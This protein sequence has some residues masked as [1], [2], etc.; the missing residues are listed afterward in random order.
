[1]LEKAVVKVVAP[2]LKVKFSKNLTT[3]YSLIDDVLIIGKDFKSA[4]E[5][6][7]AHIKDAH[8]FEKVHIYSLAMWTLFHEIGHYKTKDVSD[9]EV[10][11]DFFYGMALMNA[12]NPKSYFYLPREW[13][14]SEWAINFFTAHPCVSRLLNK[15]IR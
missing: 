9:E 15:F 11:E 5:D 7:L 12:S 3:H 14:A 10:E 8:C 4:G 6:F 2:K 13:C 1:M